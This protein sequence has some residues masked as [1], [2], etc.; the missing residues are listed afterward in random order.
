VH[1]SNGAACER[2]T[3]GMLHPV[4]TRYAPHAMVSTIDHLAT[5]VGIEL[6]QKGGSAVDAAIGANAVLSVTCPSACGMGGDLWALVHSEEGPPVAV[7]ASGMAGSLA[8]AEQARAEGLTSIPLKGDIRAVTMPGCVDGWLL[9]HD[10]FGRLPLSDVF[11]G[12]I[13]L[14]EGGFPTHPLLSASLARVAGVEH[15]E[16]PASAK[17]GDPLTRPGS[18]RA[19]RAIAS[20]G[21]AG[22]YGGE[23]G[24]GLLLV[25][26]AEFASSDLDE[27]QARWV[28][29]ISVDAFG[30]RLWT[31]PPTSQG[32]LSILGAAI[33]DG[34]E[35]GDDPRGVHLLIES[36]IQAGH[37]RPD[38]LFEGADP[39]EL[40]APSL[41][42]SRRAAIDPDR[43][44]ALTSP[45]S[46]GGTTYLCV[47]DSNGM[48]VS[49]INS[50]ASGFG[51]NLVAGSSGIF[52]QDRGLG[53]T[54][55]P[56]HPAEY[57]PRRRPPHTLAP[58]LVT[59]LDGSLRSVLGTM[60]GDAQPQ[61]VLQLL[62]ATLLHGKDPGRAV[63]QGRWRIGQDPTT[64]FD[65]WDAATG[66]RVELEEHVAASVGAGL[67]ERGHSLGTASHGEFGHAHV[68]EVS[69]HGA[70]AGAA[71]PRALVAL[72]TGY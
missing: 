52:L 5:Q 31:V 7:D 53:F 11:A 44:G 15:N 23:F 19:L 56:D 49:L 18:A 55:A 54:L 32:Y 26:S 28:M 40:L 64:G 29:P 57:G 65:T 12:A 27:T 37:D 10:R 22:F 41:V 24:E 33:A 30:H 43:A 42:A 59:H 6:L 25:G 16:L 62:A 38:V 71:D 69:P 20:Q 39:D 58:A 17:T 66:R 70:L 13:A 50:N 48:G 2:E 47:V 1:K 14:A 46:A 36:A 63:G 51:S 21:R 67:S 3:G 35:V 9:L 4:V 45:A 60:G 34:F 72:A 8:D 68:I 61:V